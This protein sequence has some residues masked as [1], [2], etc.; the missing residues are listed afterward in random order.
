MRQVR[1]GLWLEAPD[2]GGQGREGAGVT[3]LSPGPGPA[4]VGR[5]HVCVGRVGVC[6]IGEPLQ[7]LTQQRQLKYS[8]PSEI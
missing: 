4:R 1:T 3:L 6:V 5:E 7:R 8:A 2:R